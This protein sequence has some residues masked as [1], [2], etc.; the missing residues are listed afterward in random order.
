MSLAIRSLIFFGLLAPVAWAQP[1][2]VERWREAAL[3]KGAADPPAVVA[4]VKQKKNDATLAALRKQLT[5]WGEEF[6]GAA[7]LDLDQRVLSVCTDGVLSDLRREMQL[8]YV[9]K[10][11]WKHAT[12]DP[13]L[14]FR[15]LLNAG[16]EAKTV[17]AAVAAASNRPGAEKKSGLDLLSEIYGQA[18]LVDGVLVV[19][20][21]PL[22]VDAV[23]AIARRACKGFEACPFW[24]PAFVGR[25]T[26]LPA[27]G[28]A[29]Y[30]PEL[31]TL[32]LSLDLLKQ[33]T[34]LRQL[35]AIHELAHA[36]QFRAKQRTG[37]DWAQAF[38]GFSQWK[39]NASGFETPARATDAKWNDELAKE[40]IG[41]SFTLAPDPVFPAVGRLDGF[42]FAKSERETK[43]AKDVGEDLA[44][45]IAAF[46]VAPERFCHGAKPV[47]PGKYAWIAKEVFG[48]DIKLGCAP[49]EELSR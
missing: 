39:Q 6:L 9:A 35:V 14:L 2:C 37:S 11:G 41:S 15:G 30:V 27:K 25:V 44:D 7:T 12:K 45:H 31:A 36:A 5:E 43:R 18:V 32:R 3:G 20:A 21:K 19:G 8:A 40:S 34:A 23:K 48:K 13:A 1:S 16:D 22:P 49:L 42:V 24:D 46:I 47:A 17:K 28:F 26:V 10:L 38:A 29:A 33:F 4:F